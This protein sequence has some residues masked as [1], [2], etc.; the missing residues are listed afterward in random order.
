MN[1]G[2]ILRDKIQRRQITIGA[3]ATHHLW[4]ELIE[5]SHTAG[6]DYLIIDQEHVAFD[7]QLVASCCATARLMDF[8]VLIRPAECNYTLIRR[9]LDKGAVG[10]M[11]PQVESMQALAEI[12][13]AIFMPPAGRR[14]VGGPGNRWVTDF[15]HSTWQKQV[16]QD[17][18]I[19]P[20][21]ESPRGV[22]AAAE[23]ARV[24]FVT[25]LAIGPY[26]LSTELGVCWQPESPRLIGAIDAIRSAADRA[27]K[28]TLMVGDGATLIK[29]GFSLICIA[30]P[31]SFLEAAMRN[32]VAGFRSSKPPAESGGAHVP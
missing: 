25:A 20:Q 4:H 1:S 15:N 14:R 13:Q 7:E 31:T 16:E 21:I 5:I 3:I 30:E 11:I 28:N 18:I 6:L 8:P 26:D 2:Q 9:A 19:L 23:I 22:E 17:L 10:L 12:K 32:H 29:R 24:D 27:G